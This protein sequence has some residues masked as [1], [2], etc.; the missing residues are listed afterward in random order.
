MFTTLEKWARIIWKHDAFKRCCG[1]CRQKQRAPQSTAGAGEDR[2]VRGHSRTINKQLQNRIAWIS[3]TDGGKSWRRQRALRMSVTG[4]SQSPRSQSLAQSMKYTLHYTSQNS[5]ETSFSSKFK[6]QLP[7]LAAFL[8][9][10]MHHEWN[11]HKTRKF[12]T[13]S[14]VHCFNIIK[15]AM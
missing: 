7:K 1:V 3:P 10:T 15:Y 4:V 11:F 5:L 13:F 8:G 6:L 2:R 14:I 12:D 9:I